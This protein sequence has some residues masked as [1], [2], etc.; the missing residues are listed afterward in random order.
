MQPNRN[1]LLQDIVK[2][3]MRNKKS[4]WAKNILKIM[5]L[6]VVTFQDIKDMST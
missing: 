5:E 2:H 6:I 4:I 1:Q 3:E